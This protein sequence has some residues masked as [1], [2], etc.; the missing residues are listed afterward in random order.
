MENKNKPTL[1]RNYFQNA[2]FCGE[3]TGAGCRRCMGTGIGSL[4]EF[5]MYR[6]GDPIALRAQYTACLREEMSNRKTA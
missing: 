1:K 4:S 6:K 5:L 3:C 2:I